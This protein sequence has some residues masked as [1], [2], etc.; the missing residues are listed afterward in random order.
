VTIP[1]SVRVLPI[2]ISAKRYI[3]IFTWNLL[4]DEVTG[5]KAW[6][7][8]HL[9]NFASHG[10]NVYMIHNLRM[11]PRPKANADGTLAGPMDF[12]FLD[13]MLDAAKGKF[14]LY[15][16]TTDIWE[17]S[18]IRKDLFGLEITDPNYEKAFKT[19][20]GAILAHLKT[21]GITDENLLVNPYDECT[22]EKSQQIAKW[23]KEV[24]PQ[25]KI[26]IDWSP[27]NMDEA[28]KMDALTDVWVP[29]HRHFFQE[30]LQPFHKMIR[31]SKKPYWCYFYS[32][33]ANEKAQ[34]PTLHYLS[35]FWW[36]YENH[37]VGIGY[38]ANQ[39]YGNPWY[40]KAST[41]AYD[42]AMVYPIPGGMADSRRWRAWR[43]GWQDYN[44]LSI[45]RDKLEK[46]GDQEGL[47]QLKEHVQDVVST[48]GDREKC[49]KTRNWVKSKL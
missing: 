34:D 31:D 32:E 25:C 17:K 15:Y 48:P 30:E 47:K 16:M 26:V 14:D 1:I 12:M 28:K 42:T 46:S 38:W 33:G 3:N 36:C 45:L 13:K 43:C 37:L 11:M 41:T 19:W 9:K 21:K 40:R 6:F 10:V 29:H 49:E 24:D 8:A 7:D 5:N 4:P 20:F 23:M 27:A 18:W 39:Y 22:N 35:K 2:Q 44:L